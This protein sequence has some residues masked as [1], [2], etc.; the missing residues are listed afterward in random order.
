[1]AVRRIARAR[2]YV[3]ISLTSWSVEPAFCITSS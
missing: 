2:P 3:P 1:M